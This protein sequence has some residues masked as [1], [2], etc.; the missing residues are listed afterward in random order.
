MTKKVITYSVTAVVFMISIF[1]IYG[2]KEHKFIISFENDYHAIRQD[3]KNLQDVSEKISKS[4]ILD[5]FLS[6]YPDKHIAI[7]NTV[8]IGKLLK[9]LLPEYKNLTAEEAAK[10]FSDKDPDLKGVIDV[11]RSQGISDDKIFIEIT[12]STEIG[13]SYKIKEWDGND[14]SVFL[15]L[16]SGPIAYLFLSVIL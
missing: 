7:I 14:S 10:R 15:W 12:T 1:S 6:A 9:A 11:L 3:E 16:L 5:R 13:S 4:E 2:S 8:S